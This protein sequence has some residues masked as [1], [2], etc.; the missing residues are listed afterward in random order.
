VLIYKNHL[1][2]TL[3]ALVIAVMFQ[4]CFAGNMDT[5]ESEKAKKEKLAKEELHEKIEDQFPDNY[6]LA[7]D[8]GYTGYAEYKS[9]EKFTS[10]YEFGHIK[11]ND[12]RGYIIS[13]TS[14]GTYAYRFSR[15]V[16]NMEI[17]EP[18]KKYGWV[19]ALGIK[20]DKN[21]RM[22]LPKAKAPLRD[23]KIMRFLGIGKYKT[24]YGVSKNI[25]VFDR[26]EDFRKVYKK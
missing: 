7:Q 23:T 15:L 22:K 11:I 6:R 16:D 9:I 5:P 8:N 3:F 14:N 19:L 25:L 18:D 24:I 26:A 1:Q 4:G 21:R 12:Y 17:Y 20:R 2:T 10:E 13:S